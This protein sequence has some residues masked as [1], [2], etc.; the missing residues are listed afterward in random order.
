MAEPTASSPRATNSMT[1]E[2]SSIQQ[3]GLPL[4]QGFLVDSSSRSVLAVTSTICASGLHPL[5]SL[6][7][8][9]FLSQVLSD[10]HSCDDAVDRFQKF[11]YDHELPPVTP[12]TSSYCEAG[13]ACPRGSS[14]I[15][16]ARP[17][18][19]SI[20]RRT[21]HGSF[22]GDPSRSSTAPP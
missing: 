15:S 7:L 13:N 4:P 9:I 3:K 6:T 20:K 2:T 17:G 21:T 19:R 16:S 5:D 1:F 18:N 10:D 12:K 14:G 22:R 11:R 8:S